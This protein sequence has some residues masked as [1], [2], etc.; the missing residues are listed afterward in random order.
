MAN[1]DKPGTHQ[2]T[3]RQ[4]VMSHLFVAAVGILGTKVHM[5]RVEISKM[6]EHIEGEEERQA[7]LQHI[8]EELEHNISLEE[9]EQEE[10]LKERGGLEN[11]LRDS[12]ASETSHG[13]GGTDKE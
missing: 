10:L 11:T 13:V 12:D 8:L 5:N 6:E 2:L 4:L 3:T 9:A 7:D 1:H